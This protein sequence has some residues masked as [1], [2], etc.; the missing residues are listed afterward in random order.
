VYTAPTGVAHAVGLEGKSWCSKSR[1]RLIASLICPGI[2]LIASLIPPAKSSI[3]RS[4]IAIFCR[5]TKVHRAYSQVKTPKTCIFIKVALVRRAERQ[6]ADGVVQRE[7]EKFHYFGAA[8]VWLGYQP[9]GWDKNRLA[10][11]GTV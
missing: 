9:S 5:I 10:G 1:A 4:Y 7:N 2:D 3:M 6:H 11:I 8:P